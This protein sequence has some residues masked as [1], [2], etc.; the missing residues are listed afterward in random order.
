MNSVIWYCI[1][2]PKSIRN[3][4]RTGNEPMKRLSLS[5]VLLGNFEFKH[6]IYKNRKGTDPDSTNNPYKS[7]NINSKPSFNIR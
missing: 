5:Q 7:L 6:S 4:S 2:T 3:Y 1:L